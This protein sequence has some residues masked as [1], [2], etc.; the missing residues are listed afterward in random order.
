[1][2]G[3]RAP[4]WS[5][6]AKEQRTRAAWSHDPSPRGCPPPGATSSKLSDEPVDL[7]SLMRSA[8]AV[9]DVDD[10]HAGRARVQHRQER[11]NA[12]ERGAVA[13]ARRHRDDGSIHQPADDTGQ[14][15]FTAV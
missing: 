6:A 3:R 14:G 13:D 10:R 1:S 4:G 7:A 2:D 11:R 15:A 8:V 5:P 9:V 12:P